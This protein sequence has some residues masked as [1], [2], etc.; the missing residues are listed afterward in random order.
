MI[1]VGARAESDGGPDLP[2]FEVANLL[3]LALVVSE[4]VHYAAQLIYYRRGL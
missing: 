4:A 3:L 2:L 1:I